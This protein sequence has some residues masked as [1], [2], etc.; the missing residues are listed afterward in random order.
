[1]ES[2]TLVIVLDD[3]LSMLQNAADGISLFETACSFLQL[4]LPKLRDA[5]QLALFTGT[6]SACLYMPTI[7][8]NTV[9]HRIYVCR[10][11]D[12][13]CFSSS[14]TVAKLFDDSGSPVELPT[15]LGGMNAGAKHGLMQER[16]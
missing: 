9:V 4:I 6:F 5:H 16:R 7:D 1:M 12:D 11:G 3:S 10:D 13:L 14:R 8:I 15:R 2:K